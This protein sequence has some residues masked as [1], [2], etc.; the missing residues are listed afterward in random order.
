MK[1][2]SFRLRYAEDDGERKKCNRQDYSNLHATQ[3]SPIFMHRRSR[4]LPSFVS[5]LVPFLMKRKWPR[6]WETLKGF[7]ATTRCKRN[8]IWDERGLMWPF[9]HGTGLF[10]SFNI[11]PVEGV[12]FEM[13]RLITSVCINNGR[14]KIV[15]RRPKSP[16]RSL[17]K[18]SIC[19]KHPLRTF[20]ATSKTGQNRSSSS[21]RALLM[22]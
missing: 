5:N 13:L 14:L 21:C 19:D 1:L 9:V 15:K 10:K 11:H 8:Q 6:P 17:K 2:I 20:G 12:I 18:V 22:P 4:G 7:Y 3:I 16:R